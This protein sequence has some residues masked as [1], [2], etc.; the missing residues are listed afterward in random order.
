MITLVEAPMLNS[1]AL[2]VLESRYLRKDDT[3]KVVETPEQMFARVAENIASAEASYGADERERHHWA[4]VFRRTMASLDFLPNSPTLMNAGTDIQQLSACFV[5]PVEDSMEAIFD[6]IKHTALIHKSGGGT[7]FSFSRLRPRNDTVQ[8]TQG[9]S[10]GPVSFMGVFDAATETV[11]QGGRRRGANMAMLRVDHPDILDFIDSKSADDRLNNFNI[12]VA[13]TDRFMEALLEGGDYELINPRTGAVTASLPAMDV[14][15]RMVD[16]AWLNGE[17]GVIFIDRI[18]ANN[19]TPAVGAIESTNPCGEQPLLP[20]ESCNLGSVNLARFARGEMGNAEVD[21]ARL[22]E[23]VAVAVRFLDDVIDMNSYPLPEIEQLTRANR[24]IGLGVMGFADLLIQMGIAYQSP[25]AEAI[26]EDIM[27]CVNQA[28]IEASQALAKE[29]GAF[30]NFSRSVFAERGEAPRR[31]ATVTTIAPTGSISIIAGVASGVEPLFGV[32]FKRRILDGAEL[33]DVNPLFE[34]VARDEEFYSEELA[35]RIAQD[36]HVRD[37]DEVPRRWRNLFQTAHDVTPEGHIRIQAAF[38]KHTENAVSK[39]VNLAHE[40]TREDVEETFRL[41]F[42]LGCKGVTI[43]RDGSRDMQVLSTGK[44]APAP[45]A[46]REPRPRPESVS[47]RTTRMETGCGN[48]YVTTNETSDGPF[49]LFASIGKTGG[50]AASQTEAIGRLVSLS[51]RSG[52]DPNAVARQLRGVRCPYP[53]WNRGNKVLS[54]AD[55]IGQALEKFVEASQPAVS[56]NAAGSAPEIDRAER[57]AGN[58]IECGNVLEFEGGCA[59]CRVC[60]YSRC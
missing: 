7:G 57:L 20:Y 10:S 55:A 50:C 17:P 44:A 48:L 54:C 43:Y 25:E 45:G 41:A 24:K 5:L 1:N 9:V 30:P 40:S 23:V 32:A 31:N 16:R 53:S 6:S 29:R 26:A 22:R 4:E 27:S 36:G 59:V 39:T 46:R 52:V 35:A 51:L 56:Q 12:S 13:V 42:Q 3:G 18:N 37:M 47:G 14:F 60:G 28:A 19:P 33:V 2:R 8:S 49:E 58:C 11:R 34:R 15:R 21:F 38:Q